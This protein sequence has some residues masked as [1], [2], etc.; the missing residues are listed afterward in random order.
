MQQVEEVGKPTQVVQREPIT[1]DIQTQE[2]IIRLERTTVWSTCSS[3]Q[4][5][6][7]VHWDNS[8][9]E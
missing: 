5:V 4:E 8:I 2:P 7:V 6:S 9:L 1:G 3:P